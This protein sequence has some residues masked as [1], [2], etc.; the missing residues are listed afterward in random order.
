MAPTMGTQHFLMG[1]VAFFAPTA[2]FELE[3]P[4][5]AFEPGLP[6]VALEP[7]IPPVALEPEIPPLALGPKAPGSFFRP[8]APSVPHAAV[9]EAIARGTVF[10]LSFVDFAGTT[11][12][13]DGRFRSVFPCGAEV[14]TACAPFFLGALKRFS[15]AFPVASIFLFFDASVEASE[16]GTGRGP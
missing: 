3:V 13:S 1:A 10:L 6:P 8:D 14:F 9:V 15:E 7:S 16:P 4:P 12:M 2:A 11:S 5:A